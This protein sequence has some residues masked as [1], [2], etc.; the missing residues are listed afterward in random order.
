V[1]SVRTVISVVDFSLY[2]TVHA[3]PYL[4][5]YEHFLAAYDPELRKRTGSYYTPSPVVTAMTRLVDQVLRRRLDRPLGL[6]DAGV[7][8]VDPAMGTGCCPSLRIPMMASS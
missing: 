3:D 4:H 7:S 8:V 6:A 2:D 1:S 5:L